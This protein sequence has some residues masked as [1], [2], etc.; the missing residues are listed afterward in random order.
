VQYRYLYI[1]DEGK[2]TSEALADGLSSEN[3]SV[4]YKHVSGFTTEYIKNNLVDYDGILLD[5][6]LDEVPNENSEFSNFTATEFAQ[7][8]RTLVTKGEV[9]KDLPII[10]FSTDEKLQQVYSTDLSSHNLFDSYIKK[11]NTHENASKELYSLSKGY[12]KIEENK[13]NLSQ[14]M[15]LE[16]LYDLNSEIFARFNIDNPNIPAHEYAQVILKDLIYVTGVLIDEDILASR[17]GIDIKKS[18]EWNSVKKIFN[19]AK[20][21]GVFSDGW[22]KWWMFEVN[23]IFKNEFQIYLSY[24][25]AEE[26]CQAFKDKQDISNIVSPRPIELNSSNRFTTVCKALNKPL[27]SLEGYKV[28]SS[29][30][31]KQWQEYDYVSLYA[32]VSGEAEFKKIKV[33]PEDR[34]SLHDAIAELNER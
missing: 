24:L 1:D 3:I 13:N 33:H 10:L 19:S 14:L 20:Y 15:G 26:K 16:D 31:L 29:K 4:E 18:E 21:K 6:R 9:K 17:L 30:P 12:I 8:I 22:D 2:D 28:Y 5:L 34:D 25:N 11:V 23:N 32:F 7:H 27:D